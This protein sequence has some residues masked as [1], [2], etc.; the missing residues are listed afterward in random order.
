MGDTWKSTHRSNLI[1]LERNLALSQGFSPFVTETNDMTYCIV[2]PEHFTH[3]NMQHFT[4][5]RD[6]GNTESNNF[7]YKM[8]IFSGASKNWNPKRETLP[9][10]D[11]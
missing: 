6:I 9:F 2:Q 3:N 7:E 11:P 5:R 4:S 1:N 10:F 8:E